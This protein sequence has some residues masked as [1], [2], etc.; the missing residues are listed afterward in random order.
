L[1][2]FYVPAAGVPPVSV[3][4]GG[5][6]VASPAQV[7]QSS[8]LSF[9]ATNSGTAAITIAS[10]A[11][12]D[13]KGT[14]KL[15]N[16]PGAAVTLNPN[17][18]LNFGIAFTPATTGFST[19]TLQID[20]LSFTLTGSGTAPQSLPAFQFTGDSGKL[21]PLQQPSIGITLA[22]PYPLPLTGVLTI[23][24]NSAAFLPDASVQFQTGGK[25]VAVSIPANTPQALFPT[26][27]N[28][29]ALQAGTTAGNITVTPSFATATGL[30]IT[31]ANPNKV[32]FTVPASA[33]QLLTIQVTNVTQVG[34]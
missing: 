33:P 23:S 27:S 9:T 7:G 24:I 29:I 8:Q 30:D 31:P 11:V 32:T 1:T 21:T 6:M 4:A 18:T 3:L 28:Q 22:A 34:F 16:P 17:E 26:G 5:T 19:T 14:F 15:V 13:T 20:T 10:V 2:F 12:A 25:T